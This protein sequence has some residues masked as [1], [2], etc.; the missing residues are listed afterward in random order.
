MANETALKLAG[1]KESDVIGRYFWDT[2]W[3]RHSLALQE[4]L[5]IATKKASK[6]E[7]VR[8]ETTHPDPA[9]NIHDVDFSLTPLSLNEDQKID[10]LIPEGRDITR[11]KKNQ[12][13]LRES[14]ERFRSIF[15]SA[16]APMAI[17][18]PNGTFLQVNPSACRFFGYDEDEFQSLNIKD[19]T[20]SSDMENTH[21]RREELKSGN[22]TSIEYENRY[23]CKDGSTVWGHSTMA[24]VSDSEGN[25]LHIVAMTQNITEQK[26]A[27]QELV[28]YK[29]HLE[30]LVAERTQ[31]LK[32]AQLE[33]VWKE[34]LA[35]LGQL[36]ATVSHELRNPLGTIR[37]TIS[38]IAEGIDRDDKSRVLRAVK[39]A[40]RNVQRCDNIIHELLYYTRK[41]DIKSQRV[42]IDAW[43]KKILEEREPAGDIDYVF[44]P[45][46][47]IELSIDKESLRRAVINVLDNA[48]QACLEEDSREKRVL[49]ETESSGDRL[50]IRIVDNGPGI[51][52]EIKDKI[53][54]PLFSTKSFG[55]GLGIPIV[56]NIMEEH[57]GGIEIMSKEE[58]GTTVTLW[59][60]IST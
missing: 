4:E 18:A 56:K 11:I 24:S 23:L 17:I 15:E 16:A 42:D 26:L 47:G 41:R 51:P 55:V 52:E 50:E 37:N 5:K 10:Y 21:E 53:F 8:F 13:A 58:K 43:L 20:H 57:K 45:K 1:V 49:I 59:L 48:A 33:L 2:P 25:L 27:E 22:R 3:W 34:K 19:I 6:G 14:E 28:K 7:F 40:E 31:E 39:L 30:S 44:G 36:T 54:E 29:D 9:G 38:T 60:P 35:T 46:S 32:E 12:K